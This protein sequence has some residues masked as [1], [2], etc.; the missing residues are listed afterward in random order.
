MNLTTE[1]YKDI[2]F[3]LIFHGSVQHTKYALDV[4]S[5]PLVG[6]WGS[7]KDHF[8]TEELGENNGD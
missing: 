3:S 7:E 4:G 6:G 1:H 8:L 2:M 5:G